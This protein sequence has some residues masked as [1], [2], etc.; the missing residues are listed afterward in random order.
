[1]DI[2]ISWISSK[3]ESLWENFSSASKGNQDVAVSLQVWSHYSYFIDQ[4]VSIAFD[5]FIVNEGQVIDSEI[6]VPLI[7]RK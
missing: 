7:V 3:W 1:V 6:F 4:D 2:R 5:D